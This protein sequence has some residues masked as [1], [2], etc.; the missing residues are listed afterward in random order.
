[1]V[2]GPDHLKMAR[3]HSS[4]EQQF[5]ARNKLEKKYL[6]TAPLHMNEIYLTGMQNIHIKY[7]ITQLM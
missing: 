4:P 7:T 2:I 5:L 6:I 3:T 1:M